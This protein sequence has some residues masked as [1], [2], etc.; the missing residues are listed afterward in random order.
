V[1][2]IFA[3]IGGSL[4]TIALLF[5]GGLLTGRLTANKQSSKTGSEYSGEISRIV[6]LTR[7]YIT[8]RQ[9]E[10]RARETSISAR[11]AR[12]SERERLLR[13][14]EDRA[15]SDRT[16]LTELGQVLSNIVSLSETK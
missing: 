3:Y 13:E 15:K 12:V 10:L 2:K 14:A 16:D 5:G 11:E 4:L 7:G 6:E 9:T 8:E 1:Q